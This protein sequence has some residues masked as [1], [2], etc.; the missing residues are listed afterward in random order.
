MLLVQCLAITGSA[1]KQDKMRVKCSQHHNNVY[2][3]RTHNDCFIKQSP[4][5]SS[6]LPKFQRFTSGGD[7]FY[8]HYF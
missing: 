7:I 5:E 6:L 3:Y 1:S 2:E 8:I 4:I